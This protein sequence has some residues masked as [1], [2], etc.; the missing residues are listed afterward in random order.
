MNKL[1]EDVADHYAYTPA[2]K[3]SVSCA[4]LLRYYVDRKLYYLLDAVG[5]VLEWSP[6]LFI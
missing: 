4:C 5:A 2:Y 1:G 3:W 6:V